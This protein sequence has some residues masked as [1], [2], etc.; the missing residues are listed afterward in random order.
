M[1]KMSKKVAGFT[2][3]G[4]VAISS[5]GLAANK[6]DVQAKDRKKEPT[7]V[8]MMVMDGTSAGATTLSRW[9]KGENLAINEMVAGGVRTH[10]AESA[11]TDS[12][13]AATALATGNKS[14][15]KFVGVLPAVVNSPG[16]KPVSAKDAHKPVANVLEGANKGK[17]RVSFQ[18]PKSSM[19][20]QP[21]FLLM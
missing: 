19:R 20:H 7:N 18:H 14:N 9:Y 10:S 5:M 1:N 3:A 2:L 8:I 15:D 4:A 21:A 11:I 6:E 12:A 13:P 16:V 17:R